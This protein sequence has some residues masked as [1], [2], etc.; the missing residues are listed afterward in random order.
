MNIDFTKKC[1]KHFIYY[2]PNNDSNNSEKINL[3][4]KRIN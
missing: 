4:F 1:Y 2:N 3:L